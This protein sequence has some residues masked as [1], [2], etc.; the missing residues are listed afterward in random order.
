MSDRLERSA[1]ERHD[2]ADADEVVEAVVSALDRVADLA[3]AALIG[4]THAQLLETLAEISER[5]SAGLERY[6]A[7]RS[8]G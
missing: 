8:R 2:G 6:D 7:A 3:S 5:A 4:H 1:D